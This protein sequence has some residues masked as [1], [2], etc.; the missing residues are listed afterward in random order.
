MLDDKTTSKIHNCKHISTI[1]HIEA[2]IS[3]KYLTLANIFQL[4][5]LVGRCDKYVITIIIRNILMLRICDT[6]YTVNVSGC[7]Y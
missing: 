2:M 6:A 5:P 1:L 7:N 4:Y 3:L